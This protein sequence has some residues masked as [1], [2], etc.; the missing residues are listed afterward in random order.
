MPEA[1][2]LVGR[3]RVKFDP[4]AA[5]GM[6]A[7]ITLLYPFIAPHRI[8]HD[9]RASLRDCLADLSAFAFE[10]SAMRHFPTHLLYLAPAPAEI[11]RQITLAIW[12]RFPDFPPYGGRHPDIVPHLSVAQLESEAVLQPATNEFEAECRQRLP[13]RTRAAEAALMDDTN[14]RWEVREL[15]PFSR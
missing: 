8:T 1:E 9:D 5:M 12:A 14:G 3:Y 13:I 4:S 7:H 10:L 2:T 11:F 15:L 6:P